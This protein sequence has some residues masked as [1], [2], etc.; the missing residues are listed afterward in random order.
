MKLAIFNRR[1][2]R[3]APD[4]PVAR[5]AATAVELLH[6]HLDK[7]MK[8]QTRARK[9]PVKAVPL[10][11]VH[12]YTG[13]IVKNMKGEVVRLSSKAEIDAFNFM[14]GEVEKTLAVFGASC[15]AYCKDYDTGAVPD[16]VLRQ[17]KDD[18]LKK[19]RE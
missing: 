13:I 1:S 14:A 3:R 11:V 7:Y 4:N 18:L 10:E 17:F 15:K 5:Q 19:I 8:A 9:R 12:H 6:K 16:V 2:K